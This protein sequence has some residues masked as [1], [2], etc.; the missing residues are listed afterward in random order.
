MSSASRPSD[1]DVKP[2]RSAKST[3]TSRRS[4]AVRCRA[5]APEAPLRSAEPHSPQNFI[6]GAFAVPHD[7]QARA[8]ALPHSPQNLRPSSFSALQVGQT[9]RRHG[10]SRMRT[11]RAKPRRARLVG[12]SEKPPK[13]G[14][15]ADAEAL[16]RLR[17]GAGARSALVAARAAH[18]DAPD[19]GL[20]G[21][22]GR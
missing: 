11:G 7:G 6:V 20:R 21:A 18:P 16:E 19:R 4:A 14:A 8:S 9:M 13:P 5:A 17:R 12:V 1:A 22:P 10:Q 2:T 3:E 15:I